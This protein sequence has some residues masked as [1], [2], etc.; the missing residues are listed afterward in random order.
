[1]YRG[2]IDLVIT[3]AD[4]VARNGDIANK[5]G[6]YE[7]AVVAKENNIPFYI[8]APFSTIDFNCGSGAEIPIEERE[9]EEVSSVNGVAVASPGSAVKNPAFDVTPA[10]YI[11]GIITER[12]ILK[13]QTL[14]A[15]AH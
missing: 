5:I 10:K 12:G 9:A 11:S 1:M 3:G 7:K 13:P 4:R 8:A 14:A 15:L 2:E 6:T